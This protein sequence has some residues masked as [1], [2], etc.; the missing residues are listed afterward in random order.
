[1]HQYD[2][3]IIY[4]SPYL[5]FSV[6]HSVHDHATDLQ[7]THVSLLTLVSLPHD[8]AHPLQARVGAVK[9]GDMTL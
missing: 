1:M 3:V 6:P 2:S 5:L 4:F 7:D 9:P 8:G